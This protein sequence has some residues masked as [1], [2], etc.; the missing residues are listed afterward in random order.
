MST[1]RKE[2]TL[3]LPA[4]AM[5]IVLSAVAELPYRIAR[6]LM[7]TAEAQFSQQQHAEEPAPPAA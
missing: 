5:E 6:P 4:E 7:Q 3:T 1:A 2:F